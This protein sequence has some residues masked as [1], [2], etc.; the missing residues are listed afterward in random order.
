MTVWISARARFDLIEIEEFI[1]QDNPWRASTYLE[2]IFVKIEGIGNWPRRY[3]V[4]RSEFPDYRVARH[5]K[6]LIL[7]RLTDGAPRIERVIHGAR[8]AAKLLKG[9]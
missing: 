7:F 8:D 6:Y 3:P 9:N 4:W 2:E 1:A 5:G